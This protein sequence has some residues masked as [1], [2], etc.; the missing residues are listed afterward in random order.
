MYK[1]RE[2]SITKEQAA[3]FL[4]YLKNDNDPDKLEYINGLTANKYMKAVGCA[5]RAAY[6]E[7]VTVGKTDRE[8]YCMG[9]IIKDEPDWST[10]LF[11]KAGDAE[12]IVDSDM[13]SAAD[14]YKVF[15]LG[16]R[17]HFWEIVF[18]YVELIPEEPYPPLKI[19]DESSESEEHLL[20]HSWCY[21]L[22]PHCRHCASRNNAEMLALMYIALKESGFPVY[23]HEYNEDVVN[24]MK[25]IQEQQ[26]ERH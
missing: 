25:K 10:L 22:S 11:Y 13:D 4:E 18:G 7:G 8:L 9:R 16:S 23:F 21:R 20:S 5:M 15:D 6:K 24:Y 2:K 14:F 26:F 19:N 3:K 17:F 1:K 12:K